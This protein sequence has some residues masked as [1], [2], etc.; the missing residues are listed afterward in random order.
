MG[1]NMEILG[2]S[3]V[4]LIVGFVQLAKKI[5]FPSQFAGLLSLLLGI[6]LSFSFK[7]FQDTFTFQT[8][9]L[10]LALGLSASGLY[11]TTK[12]TLKG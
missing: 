9:L 3:G 6:V 10:G 12:H 5:G 1:M 4:A 11:S 7:L 8:L 2:V